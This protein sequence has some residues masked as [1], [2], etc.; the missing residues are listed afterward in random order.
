MQKRYIM[1]CL[2]NAAL[3]M[4][5][6]ISSCSKKAEDI[7]APSITIIQPVEYD[8]IQLINGFITIDVLAQDHVRVSDMKM[9][10]K[11]NSG[12][13][14]YTYEKDNIENATYTCHEQFYPTG[15]TKVTQ[16]KLKVTFSNEYENW[17]SKTI[18]FY[19][20]P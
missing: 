3:V 2:I 13:V 8:T 15:I 18:N 20:K 4:A 7:A 11:D 17:T 16:M 6:V 14:L 12:T 10:I 5:I 1:F 9:T 19:V